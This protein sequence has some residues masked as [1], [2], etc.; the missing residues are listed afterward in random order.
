MF[1]I[2]NL[3]PLAIQADGFFILLSIFIGLWLMS[4]L[5]QN[6]QTNLELIENALLTGFITG[7]VGARI[8]YLIQNPTIFL[9]N[10]ASLIALRA[11][12]F[13]VGFGILLSLIVV[14]IIGQKKNLPLWP[15][16]DTITPLLLCLSVGL[17]LANLATGNAYGIPTDLPWGIN[18]WNAQRHPIQI[19]YLLLIA[20][21]FGAMLYKTKL[22]KTTGFTRSGTLFLSSTAGISLMIVI[23]RPLVVEKVPILFLDAVQS[24]GF[25]MLTGSF[26]L[27]YYRNYHK[28]QKHQHV[29]ISLGSNQSPQEHLR[30]AID[31]LKA[32][33]QFLNL[34]SFYIS[35]NA[36]DSTNA[37][38]FWNCALE[39]LT[40]A[41][42]DDLRRSLKQ[43]EDDLGRERKTKTHV[44][45]D[46][47]ILT[48]GDHVFV[49]QQRHIP[50]PELNQYLYIT[51]PIS[52]IQ[53]D[54]RHP[55]SGISIQDLIDAQK[56]DQTPPQKIERETER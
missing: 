26:Y 49:H 17:Q 53:P 29:L 55:A 32:R 33:Y 38:D 54:F 12:M 43:I 44:R 40:D 5:A 41:S 50:D 4:Q 22:L 14:F 28:F 30:Q 18:L 24:G 16:L 20:I 45:I 46:L 48:Y 52:E 34:S 15:T 13:N 21:L 47:D 19:Y 35:P 51:L 1:P 42:Y 56:K 6:L 23:I 31:T 11:S 7:L 2:L 36:K 39:I 27:I 3:G 37:P 9:E 25:L 10:P 8:G